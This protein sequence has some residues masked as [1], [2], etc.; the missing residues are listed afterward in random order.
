MKESVKHMS[1]KVDEV[2]A[3]FAD[4]VG[5]HILLIFVEVVVDGCCSLCRVD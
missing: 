4:A 5:G 1:H 3:F 2:V